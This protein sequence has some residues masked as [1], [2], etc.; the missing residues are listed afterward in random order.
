[1]PA[2]HVLLVLWQRQPPRAFTV[3]GVSLQSLVF[4]FL[5]S[6]RTEAAWQIA[7]VAAVAC[8]T[9]VVLLRPLRGQ[10]PR[11]LINRLGPL[12][13]AA[14]LL[15]VTAAYATI[16]SMKVDQRYSTEPKGHIIWHEILLGMLNA[17]PELRREYAGT[18]NA[19]DQAVYLAVIRD[20]KARGDASSPIVRKLGNGE[21]T[22]DLMAGWSE[23]EKLVR[24]LTLRIILHHPLVLVETLPTKVADQLRSY[25]NPIKHSMAWA[26]LR[27]PVV[28]IAA[29]A[30]I[31]M[32][33]GGF[34]IGLAALRSAAI[35]VAVLLLF[36]SVTPWIEPSP[37]SIG[38]LFSYLGV[39]AILVPYVLVSLARS[40][41]RPKS[42]LE[43][44]SPGVKS[45]P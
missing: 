25:N 1:M 2:L 23:Y 19:N 3:A 24:S 9:G 31:C 27:I 45:G 38:S 14:V 17:S 40:L 8:G 36:A 12:W 16:V 13:P 35:I 10:K 34:T 37:L 42:R 7:M 33:A 26:N 5:L 44:A 32:A 39:I 18:D 11:H 6:C 4:A 15:V 41:V 20:L 30:L 22:I 28:I 21:L 29:G 43:G